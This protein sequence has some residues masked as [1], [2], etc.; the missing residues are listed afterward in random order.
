M[1]DSSFWDVTVPRVLSSYAILIFA[2][3]WVGFVIT[4]VVNRE[5]LT[6][7]WDWVQALPSV[8]K[9]IF[10]LLFLPIMVGLW[11]WESSWP[12]LVQVSSFVGIILWTYLAVSSFLR[13]LR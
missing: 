5:W 6:L 3:L 1:K 10:W 7:L 4:L 8:A 13:A 12:I 11:I 9:I 2:I